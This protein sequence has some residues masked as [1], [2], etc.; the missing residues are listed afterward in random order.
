[1]TWLRV[2]RRTSLVL[3][4]VLVLAHASQAALLGTGSFTVGGGGGRI[5]PVTFGVGLDAGSLSPLP[6]DAVLIVPQATGVTT[7]GTGDPG[8]AAASSLLTDGLATAFGAY[9]SDAGASR[10]WY[11][12]GNECLLFFGDG[13]CGSGTDFLG[14]LISS[15]SVNV[16]VYDVQSPGSDP[17]SD[18]IWTDFNEVQV[19]VSV[20]GEPIPAP[21]TLALLGIGLASL[22]VAKRRWAR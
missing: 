1:M 2:M 12:A 5:L 19:T 3:G 21:A 22:G 14:E 13:S 4:G 9:W 11:G 18:G 17:N 8:F 6:P 16:T 10:T 7:F 20:F 15:I